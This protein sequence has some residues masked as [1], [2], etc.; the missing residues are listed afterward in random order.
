MSTA[1]HRPLGIT[2]IALVFLL[3][4]VVALGLAAYLLLSPTSYALYGTLFE[5]MHWS[6]ALSGLLAVPPL[7]AA[8][9][10]GLIFRGLWHGRN[11]ARLAALVAVF[12]LLLAVIAAIAFLLAFDIAQPRNLVGGFVLALFCLGAFI[13][14]VRVRLDLDETPPPVANPVPYPAMAPP[15]AYAAAASP[16]AAPLPY[17]EQRPAAAPPVKAAGDRPAPY[18][19]VAGGLVP[20]PP[21]PAGEAP[22]GAAA[23]TAGAAVESPPVVAEPAPVT[24]EVMPPTQQIVVPAALQ[25]TAWLVVRSGA[26][27]GQAFPLTTGETLL[28]GRD[29]ARVDATLTDPTVS[30]RHAQVRY[31]QDRFVLYDLGST[32]GTYMGGHLIQRQPL[33]DGDELQLGNSLLLFTTHQPGS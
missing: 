7:L 8:A 6:A 29:A 15:V 11:W 2:I 31:E 24:A 26:Q 33:L 30:S 23:A 5:R 12:L 16:A 20:P 4:T 32:N 27:N 25:P 17:V 1:P 3:E 22:L 13:Y 18:A 28:I 21:R 10:A 14:L 9:L 19:N